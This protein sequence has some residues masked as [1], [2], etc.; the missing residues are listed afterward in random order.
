MNYIMKI[1]T[2]PGSKSITNR[3]LVLS[4]LVNGKTTLKSILK[5]DDTH[6]MLEALKSMGA[7]IEE[8]K[9][10]VKIDVKKYD[11]KKDEIYVGQSWTCM[12]FL[13]WFLVIL[14]N[15]LG[16]TPVLTGEERLLQR[17]L[18]DLID[19]I[20]QM[21]YKVKSNNGFPPVS[22][23]GGSYKNNKIK[24]NGSKSSQFFTALLN[25]APALENGLEIEVVWDL[26]S[27]P[28][29]DLTIEEMKK[30]WVDVE[31]Y[32]YKKFVVKP[33]KYVSQELVVEGDAS[34]L[35]YIVNF[36]VLHWWE[37]RV[38]NIWNS[39]KQWD[40]AYLDV[41]K[42]Y[43]DFDYIS[44]EKTT[45]LKAN[46]LDKTKLNKLNEIDFEAMP[47]VSM[48]FMSL[49][50]FLPWKTK[51]TWLQ[52]LNLKESKRIDAMANEL[53]KL[54]VDV[55]YDEKSITIWEL[56][57]IKKW[58]IDIETYNDHR[59]AMVFGTLNTYLKNMNI[60]NPSCVNKTYPN[61]WNDM[62]YLSK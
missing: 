7:E 18:K 43:F 36:V 42:K 37:I 55:E 58:P 40:Y 9:D 23:V 59:I 62:N 16:K 11:I 4:M 49:A 19:G 51:I 44:D 47:D 35:S 61:F 20:E 21:W 1:I 33:W 57:E 14:Y 30:F 54:W 5:S 2:L 53:K 12:R 22:I 24:M 15:K 41:V 56:N 27:K 60:L 46:K 50:I 39:T 3:D 8:W 38:E 13:T 10:F 26:V 25:I 31:N 34:A 28:Y 52:T 6:Y 48:S 29:I 45:T 17:P 32:D